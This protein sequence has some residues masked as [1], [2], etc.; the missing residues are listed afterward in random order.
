PGTKLA[1]FIVSAFFAGAAGSLYAAYY[2]YISPLV[3]LIEIS[4]NGLVVLGVGGSLYAAYY[5]CISPLVFTFEYSVNVLVF[6][7]VGGF[8]SLA[9]PISGAVVLTLVPE[10]FRV[11]GKYQ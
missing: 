9:G 5:G 2:G 8:A 1:A 6:I 4:R 3:F 10:L 11:T 7:V